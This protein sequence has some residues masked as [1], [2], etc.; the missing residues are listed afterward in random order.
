LQ[1]TLL[2]LSYIYHNSMTSV[3]AYKYTAY[4]IKS[5]MKQIKQRSKKTRER[6]RK[7]HKL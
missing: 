7:A 6:E 5:Y 1:E 3:W 2:T 4:V